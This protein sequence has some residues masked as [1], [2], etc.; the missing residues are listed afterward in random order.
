MVSVVNGYICY[1]SCDVAKA[2]QNKNP[3]TPPGDMSDATKSDSKTAT[4][5]DQPATTRSGALANPPSRNDP[6]SV[7]DPAKPTSHLVDIRA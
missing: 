6:V 2:E 4:P 5:A 7:T 3:R 1:S